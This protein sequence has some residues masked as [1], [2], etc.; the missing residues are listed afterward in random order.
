MSYPAQPYNTAP[1]ERQ[2]LLAPGQPA[3]YPGPLSPSP[4]GDQN[5]APPP[6]KPMT[7][8]ELERSHTR[9][10][11]IAGCCLVVLFTIALAVFLGVWESGVFD[12]DP[13]AVA[14]DIL[15][16]SPVIVRFFLMSSNL[17]I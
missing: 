12:S 17:K 10:R 2:P 4:Y 13:R 9:R 5:G 1:P 15:K 6:R 16:H 7:D 14:H 3:P 8:R 11:A